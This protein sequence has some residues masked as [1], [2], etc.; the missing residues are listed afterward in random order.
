MEILYVFIQHVHSVVLFIALTILLLICFT[1]T[2]SFGAQKPVK[3]PPGPPPLPVIGNLLQLDLRRIH[4]VLLELSKK[5]GSIFTIYLGPKKVVVLAGYK[6]VKEALVNCAEV[7]GQRDLVRI[8]DELIHGHGIIW[9]ND[10]SW[11]DMRR[12][13]MMSLRD[14]GMGKK[15]SEDKIIEECHHLMEAFEQFKGEAFDANQSISNA[16]AN[17]ICSMIY[18]SR[19]DYSDPDFTSLVYRVCRN[20]KLLNTPSVQLYNLFPWIGK[21]FTYPKLFKKSFAANRKHQL[22]LLSHLKETLNPKMC[23]GFVDAFLVRQENLE[24]SGITTSHF[25]D[26][27][28]LMTVINL[29]VGGT[30][31]SSRTLKWGLF[32]MAKYPK[33]Q[34]KVQEE[35]RRVIGDRQARFRDR[36]DLPFTN[37][38]IHETQRLTAIA[39]LGLPHRT[40]RDIIFRGH[41]IKKGTAVYPFLMSV[42]S[43]EREWEKPNT[44]YPEHF[45]DKDGKFFKRDAFMAFSAGSRICPGESLARM[46]LLIFFAT[47]LQHFRFT[48]PPGVSQDDLS[49]CDSLIL[50]PSDVKLCAVP[51]M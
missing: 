1:S 9:A 26:E 45:L 50:N 44:F 11:K 13:A 10:E 21:W 47:L 19:F 39:A 40:A 4:A 6:T 51:V 22:K 35:L 15:E 14:F 24:K 30:E 41:F 2:N 43:D 7:F 42:L 48:L 25:H 16:T 33:I 20:N 31:T 28:L 46:E 49:P 8:M 29:F 34:D 12:F 17:I 37:A 32:L 27:N 36:I 38:V 23:R 18:G 5:Y 3:E